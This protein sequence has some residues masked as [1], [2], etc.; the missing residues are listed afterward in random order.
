MENYLDFFGLNKFL[1]L[2]LKTSLKD[3]AYSDCF[4]GLHGPVLPLLL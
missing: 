4:G 3:S 2:E 1:N